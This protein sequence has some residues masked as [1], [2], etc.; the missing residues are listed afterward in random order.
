MDGSSTTAV[1]DVVDDPTPSLSEWYNNV[2]C[3]G[4]VSDS[5]LRNCMVKEEGRF[6]HPRSHMHTR[7][8]YTHTSAET[9]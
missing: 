5:V 6:L 9:H 1:T 2:T 7:T 4:V 8:Q 3:E